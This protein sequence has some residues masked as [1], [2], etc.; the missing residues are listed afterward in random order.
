MWIVAK[1]LQAM[2]Q[3]RDMTLR[4]ALLMAR[5]NVNMQNLERI[6]LQALQ[7]K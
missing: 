7:D 6:G 2:T 5:N 1:R 3:I 4:S